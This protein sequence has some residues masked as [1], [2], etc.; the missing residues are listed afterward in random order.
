MPRGK[1]TTRGFPRLLKAIVLSFDTV[2]RQ[3]ILLERKLFWRGT[4]RCL[5]RDH[6]THGLK[7]SGESIKLRPQQTI[8]KKLSLAGS[9]RSQHKLGRWSSSAKDF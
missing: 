4:D 1:G 3:N 8:A 5:F 7:L 6:L 2:L 9:E